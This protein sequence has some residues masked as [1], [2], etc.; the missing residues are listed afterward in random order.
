M[1][2]LSSATQIFS[3]RQ[4][5]PPIDAI[6]VKMFCPLPGRRGVLPPFCRDGKF[7]TK[8]AYTFRKRLAFFPQVENSVESVQKFSHSARFS[9]GIK[10]FPPSFQQQLPPYPGKSLTICRIQVGI[11][12]IFRTGNCLLLQF[13]LTSF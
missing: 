10:Q 2:I 3:H 9:G 7:S 8:D 4:C 12:T 6:S 5:F 1:G 11:M 13:P